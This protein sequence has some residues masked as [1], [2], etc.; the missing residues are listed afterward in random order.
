M[1]EAP[2]DAGRWSDGGYRGE[3][4]INKTKYFWAFLKALISLRIPSA[5]VTP[6]YGRL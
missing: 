3:L 2:S 6:P 1:G 5:S 4:E